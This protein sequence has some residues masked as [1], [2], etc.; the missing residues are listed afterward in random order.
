MASR[1]KY[2]ASTR[3]AMVDACSGNNGVPDHI[4]NGCLLAGAGCR[5]PR[6]RM[7]RC[8]VLATARVRELFRYLVPD[9][10]EAGS[11]RQPIDLRLIAGE[12]M[13][14]IRSAGPPVALEVDGL[15]RGCR[16]RCVA[17]IEAHRHDF[18]ILTRVQRHH[19]ER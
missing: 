6:C 12:K 11:L 17:R 14:S 4:P 13:P 10:A 8:R 16:G 9:V 18:E 15:L 2:R 7:P 3:P 5:V 19:T 1:K